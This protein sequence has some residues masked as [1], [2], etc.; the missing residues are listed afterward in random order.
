MVNRKK[1]LSC[2][3]AASLALT[4]CGCIGV[5]KTDDLCASSKEGLSD[6]IQIPKTEEEWSKA[7]G[8]AYYHY[9]QLGRDV[10]PIG[11]WVAPPSEWG[12]YTTNQITKN[13]YRVVAESGL[14]SIYALYENAETCLQRILDALDYCEEFG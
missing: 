1:Y 8:Y 7:G 5:E 11:A 4:A 12:S 6:R 14:N 10:M 9:Q 2:T 13:N 3:S